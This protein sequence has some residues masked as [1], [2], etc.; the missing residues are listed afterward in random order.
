MECIAGLAGAFEWL[1]DR[2]RRKAIPKY[3]CTT[4]GISEWSIRASSQMTLISG[5]IGDLFAWYGQPLGPST[6][7]DGKTNAPSW[8]PFSI[9]GGLLGKPAAAAPGNSSASPPAASKPP[10]RL[11]T[12][13][14]DFWKWRFML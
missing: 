12:D 8:S 11:R 13:A 4:V 1:E 7:G 9:V 6:D 10:A 3:G 5:L 14:P 2:H